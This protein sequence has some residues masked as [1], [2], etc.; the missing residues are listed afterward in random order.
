MEK[1]KLTSIVTA[2]FIAVKAE[3][4]RER[5]IANLGAAIF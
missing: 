5:A 3:R 1:K 2:F 4:E